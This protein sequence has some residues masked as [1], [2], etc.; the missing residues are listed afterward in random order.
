MQTLK[1]TLALLLCCVLLAAFA[2][3]VSA[4]EKI[5]IEKAYATYTVPV[6][7]EPFD[8]SAITVPD[9]AHYTAEITAAF[10]YKDDGI[11]NLADG[12]IV[13]NNRLYYVHIHFSANSGYYLEYGKTEYTING[14]VATIYAGT[15]TPR[16][17][18]VPI[19]MNN[20]WVNVPEDVTVDYKSNVTVTATASGLPAGYL[21]AL[22]D[23]GKQLAKSDSGTVSYSMGKMKESKTLTAKIIDVQGNA[24][25]N[26]DG[27]LE[28]D[29]T[30]TVKT[31]FFAKLIAF[32]KGLFG[33]L[34]T[35][36]LEP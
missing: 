29:F 14:S 23:G 30:I 19:N 18:F 13:E 22:Y 2:P 6:A 16:V 5:L 12:D 27:I 4:E 7:G 20:V 25:A 33:L 26:T 10:C 11:N 24:Q 15:L 36:V 32:F 21:V 3:M 35:V 17:S 28:K 31:G 9:D 8:F 34:P 1:R